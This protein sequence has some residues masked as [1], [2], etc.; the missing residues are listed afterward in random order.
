MGS[1]PAA[2]SA[3]CG[4]PLLAVLVRGCVGRLPAGRA[5]AAFVSCSITGSS[6]PSG[7]L[8]LV[9]GSLGLVLSGFEPVDSR[10]A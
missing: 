2:E 9:S 8:A 5:T 6:A 4:L 1:G 7:E 3:R 10:E